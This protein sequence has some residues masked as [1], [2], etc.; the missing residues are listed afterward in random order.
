MP[1]PLLSAH[2][3]VLISNHHKRIAI[4]QAEWP[5]QSHTVNCAILFA[6]AGYEVDLF[7]FKTSGYVG[8][9]VLRQVSNVNL[10]DFSRINDMNNSGTAHKPGFK[11]LVETNIKKWI[12]YIVTLYVLFLNILD[13]VRCVYYLLIRREMKG[14]LK[15]KIVTNALEIMKDKKYSFLIGVEKKGLLWAGQVGESLN[16]PSIYYSLELYTDDFQHLYKKRSIYFK[17]LRLAESA[18]HKKAVATI[19][20][21]PERANVLFHDNGVSVTDANVFYVP[22]SVTGRHYEKR[23]RFFHKTLGISERKKVILYFGVIAE[24]RCALELVHIAQGFPEDWVLVFHGWGN[25]V[26]INKIKRL[27]Y[28]KKVFLSLNMVP[29]DRIQE[30]VASADVGL[31]LYSSEVQN[32]RLTAFSSEKIAYYMQCG[33]PFIGFNYP[34]Y[35]RLE[36]EERCGVTINSITD[37]PGAVSKILDAY[38]EFH[39]NAYKTYYKYYDFT[40]NFKGVIKGVEKLSN[41]EAS[42]VN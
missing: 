22:V 36:D 1:L 34:G 10:Y 7:L 35:K 16:I 25:P 8:L 12:P 18:F 21:D 32:D 37:I 20:Q 2:E 33:V 13:N 27:D 31:V 26:V 19:I 15:Q 11:Q 5:L 38:N 3:E 39:Q 30:I 9:D 14:L 41:M 24:D 6:E 40:N 28:N 23:H 4:F 29:S 42:N 17:R